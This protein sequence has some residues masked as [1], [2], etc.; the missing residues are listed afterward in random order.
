MEGPVM[1]SRLAR[2]STQAGRQ[3]F[4]TTAR[5]YDVLRDP[6][7]NGSSGKSVG[8]WVELQPSEVEVDGG[9]EVLAVA[10]AAG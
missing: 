5:G 4:E 3:V 8:L 10:V 2:T 9:F 1:Y 7:L 6:L